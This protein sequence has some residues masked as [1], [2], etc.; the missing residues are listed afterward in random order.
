[1]AKTHAGDFGNLTVDASG[2]GALH[3]VVPGLTLSRAPVAVAGHAMV[4]HEKA[5]DFSQPVGNAGGRIGC[6]VITMTG[7]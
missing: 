5:D 6:G 2:K 3:T 1:V 4:L 7:R